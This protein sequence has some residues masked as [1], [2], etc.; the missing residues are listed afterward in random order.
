MSPWGGCRFRNLPGALCRRPESPAV[1]SEVQG[2]N[3]SVPQR[4]TPCPVLCPRGLTCR[5][6]HKPTGLPQRGGQ[7]I[8]SQGP[9]P[10]GSSRSSSVPFTRGHAHSWFLVGGPSTKPLPPQVSDDPQK[11]EGGGRPWFSPAGAPYPVPHGFLTLSPLL[12]CF[13]TPILGMVSGVLLCSYLKN[14]QITPSHTGQEKRGHRISGTQGC[15]DS[16]KESR[17]WCIITTWGGGCGKA[18]EH[19]VVV[20]H[21]CYSNHGPG[22]STESSTNQCRCWSETR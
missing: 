13:S 4:A 1:N 19:Q 17:W 8:S 6:N 15:C 5:V 12:M 20:T 10:A 11:A 16:S 21:S 18:L 9:L 7:G 22:N 3:A 2:M 14:T